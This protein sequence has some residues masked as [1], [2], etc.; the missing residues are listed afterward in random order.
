MGGAVSSHQHKPIEYRLFWDD[1][2]VNTAWSTDT[3]LIYHMYNTSGEFEVKAQ[4]RCFYHPAIESEW[5]VATVVTVLES[6]TTHSACQGPEAGAI[7]T[8]YT[9]YATDAATTSEGHDVEYQ[10]DFDDGT[11]S[12]WSASM[13]A[14]HI[15]TTAGYYY[16]NYRARC[17]VHTAAVSSVAYR[18]VIDITDDP[19]A[20]SAAYI[21]VVNPSNIQIGEEVSIGARLSE[22]NYGDSL[23]YMIEFGD[24]MASEWIGATYSIAF[25]W[26]VQF[27]HTYSALGTYDARCRSRCVQHPTVMSAWSP[28]KPIEVLETLLAMGAPT[29][30]A[31]GAVG[32]NLTFTTT[33]TTSDAGHDLEYSFQYFRYSSV[34]AQS[35]WSTSLT[36]THVFTTPG[37]SIYRVRV[38][39]RCIEHPSALVY[40]EYSAYFT[41]TAK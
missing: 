26:G 40:S 29:G 11:V 12:D 30:P 22:S 19:E 23:E 8:S 2:S 1:G 9:F 20:L 35:D 13:S 16:V 37:A 15:F 34:Q 5:S 25:K 32:E 4:A 3:T 17:A 41:I 6:V 31:T 21:G 39:A 18:K 38:V 28:I 36:D 33:G 14:D 27:H 24:G 10:F 7:N